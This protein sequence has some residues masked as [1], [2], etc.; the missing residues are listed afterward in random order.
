[1]STKDKIDQYPD[2]NDKMWMARFTDDTYMKYS[3]TLLEAAKEAEAE[4][5]STGVRL[6]MLSRRY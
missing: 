2:G 6:Q 5:E 3:G 4:A 1:M